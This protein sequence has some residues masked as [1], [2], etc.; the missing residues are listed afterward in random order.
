MTTFVRNNRTYF[1]HERKTLIGHTHF[2]DGVAFSPDKKTL[3]SSD[4]TGTIRLWDV[5]TGKY[6]RQT[7]FG[8][9]GDAPFSPDGKMLVSGYP[10]ETIRL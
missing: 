1:L 8:K 10:D 9:M 6:Q 2:V 7:F 4:I 3:A 5:T